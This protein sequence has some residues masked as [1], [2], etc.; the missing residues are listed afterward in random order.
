[1]ITS[2]L[3]SRLVDFG[4]IRGILVYL[5]V[6]YVLKSDQLEGS[7]HSIILE[8][9]DVPLVSTLAA[10]QGGAA[11]NIQNISS[12]LELFFVRLRAEPLTYLSL[13]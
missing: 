6:E 4:P 9:W 13:F 3:C 5:L 7:F 1:M 10:S 11:P 12:K 2:W 8:R